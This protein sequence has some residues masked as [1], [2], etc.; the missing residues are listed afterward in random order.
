MTHPDDDPDVAQA[1]EFLDMLTAHAAR[2]ET[3]MAMAGSPQQRAAWQSDLRQIRR[4]I[5]GLHR[6]FPD[7][8]AE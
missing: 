3:D 6:R 8:A 4:F 1:R 5:D 2:L 7:L